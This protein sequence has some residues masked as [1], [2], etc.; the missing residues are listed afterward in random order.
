V[1]YISPP[2][3]LF[4]RV[5]AAV[6]DNTKRPD[7]ALFSIKDDP[8]KETGLTDYSK[9]FISSVAGLLTANLSLSIYSWYICSL[10]RACRIALTKATSPYLDAPKAEFDFYIHLRQY[11]FHVN[12]ENSRH[13]FHTLK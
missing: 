8:Q 6:I 1:I 13:Q 10:I 5:A 12:F 11:P 2:P 7:K 3:S 9:E 4:A